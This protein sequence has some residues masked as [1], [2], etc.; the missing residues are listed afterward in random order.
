MRLTCLLLTGPD[1]TGV[2]GIGELAT[3]N[4]TAKVEG[5]P[6]V[7]D[8]CNTMLSN[9]DE[10]LIPHQNVDGTVTVTPEFP[11]MFPVLLFMVTVLVVAEDKLKHIVTC[12]NQ[13]KS[14]YVQLFLTSFPTEGEEK[15][16][17]PF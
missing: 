12:L 9:S 13:F 1:E 8:L 7:L 11:S 10:K 16:T 4:F 3:L 14:L 17:L 5:R 6:Y 15:N 2:N